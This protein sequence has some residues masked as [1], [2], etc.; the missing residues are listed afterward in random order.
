[1]TVT[2]DQAAALRAYLAGDF[3]THRRL[4]GQLDPAAA[5][6]GY[7]ALLGAAFCVAVEHRFTGNDSPAAV[8]DFVADVRSRSEGLGG[9]ID[10]VAAERLIRAVYTDE[11]IDD[12]DRETRIR[13]QFLLLAALV[14]D[15]HLDDAGL[16]AFTAEARKLAD[17]WLR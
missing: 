9:K 15:E 11:Q 5:A 4:R 6:T 13:S 7:A 8:I 3:D 14:V 10:P 12:L 17:A 2:D 1:M 16:D